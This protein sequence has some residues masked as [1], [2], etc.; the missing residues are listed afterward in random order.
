M[1]PIAVMRSRGFVAVLV[2]AAVVG[3][4]V[5]FVGW[6]FL[7]LVHA[8]QEGIFLDLPDALGFDSVP[9]WWAIPVCA[10]AAIPVAMAIDWLPGAGGHVPAEG[11]KAGGASGPN[12]LPGVT[13]AAFATLAGGLV[14]G[15]EAPLIAIGSGVA[16]FVAQRVKRDATPTMLTVLGAAGSFAA[17]SVVFGSPIMA[18]IVIIEASG[19]GGAMLP[20]ML[21]PGLIAAGI[22][23]LVFIG[24]THWTGLDTTAYSMVPLA[25]QAFG[26]P[27]AGEIAWT[28]G[29]GIVGAAIVFPIRQLGLRIAAVAPRRTFAVVVGAGLVVGALAFA[30]AELTDEPANLVLFSG[31]D[32]LNPLVA[33]ATSLTVGTLVLLMAFKGLAWGLS[34]GAF[35][36]GPTFPALFLGAVGGIAV[37]HLPGLEGSVAIPVGMGVMT[38]AILRLPLSSIVIASLLCASAGPGSAPLVILGVVVAYIATL[39]L[40]GAF[41]TP[42]PEA[43]DEPSPSA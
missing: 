4:I 7:E 30:F 37:S 27:T 40:E 18:A 39:A 36:G 3:I 34:L 16:I 13:M 20:L 11:L 21:I 17:I 42:A 25:L 29:L 2:L 43:A 35:R 15:P 38:V 31:Q 28:I 33:N 9:T 23:S 8:A 6:A 10:L 24:M 26:T 5:S 1:D 32:Q 22:G 41:D 19:L 12:L 14:L